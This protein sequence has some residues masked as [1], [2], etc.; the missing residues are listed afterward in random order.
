[1]VRVSADDLQVAYRMTIYTSAGA[2]QPDT[3]GETYPMYLETHDLGSASTFT[4]AF[5]IGDFETD[6][7]GTLTLSDCT[8]QRQDVPE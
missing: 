1:M 5:E 2:I 3:D 7:G 8:L 6:K 4:L